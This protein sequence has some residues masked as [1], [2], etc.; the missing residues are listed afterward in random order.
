M[1]VLSQGHDNDRL[2]SASNYGDHNMREQGLG[3][4]RFLD[5]IL[6][7]SVKKKKTYS[8]Q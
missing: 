7:M 4:I 5:V 8:C 6:S 3:A 1:T 2:E